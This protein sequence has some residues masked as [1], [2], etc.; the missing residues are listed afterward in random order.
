MDALPE[1]A[2]PLAGA[3]LGLLS[4]PVCKQLSRHAGGAAGSCPRCHAKLHF[5]K[6]DSHNRCWACLIAA[7]L[8]YFPANILPVMQTSTL[9]GRQR[10]TILSGVAYLWSAGSWPLAL[11]VFVASVLVPL[12]KIIS[13]AF[14]LLSIRFRW[15][16]APAQR[17]RLYRLLEVVG[18]WSM[19]DIYVIALLVALVRLRGLA[20]VQAEPGAL[21]F[22]AVVVL[23]ILAAN[24][25]DP[26]LIWDVDREE[27]RLGLLP[28]ATTES[29]NPEARK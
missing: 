26:R 21:A 4:C 6:P 7:L 20:V 18:S 3:D 25:F 16:W 27:T 22:A 15:R 9:F 8:C 11:V 29:A 1:F 13:L 24:A 10:D 19:L 17:T 12:L 28:E 2:K 14:L 5:R 23:T